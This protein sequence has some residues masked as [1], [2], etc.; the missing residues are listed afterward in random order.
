MGEP[1]RALA[2][3]HVRDDPVHG[4]ARLSVGA[5]LLHRRLGAGALRRLQDLHLSF[6]ILLEAGH[7][8]G[9]DAVAADDAAAGPGPDVEAGTARVAAADVLREKFVGDDLVADFD[10]DGRLAEIRVALVGRHQAGQVVGQ[11]L[12]A[13]HVPE[14]VLRAVGVVP[15]RAVPPFAHVPSA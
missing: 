8:A 10:G 7:L 4:G 6:F 15:R 1:A 5:R 14:L 12:L 13:E 3:R 11:H 9:P 2:P